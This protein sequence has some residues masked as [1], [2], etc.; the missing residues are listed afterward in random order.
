MY[1]IIKAASSRKNL[2]F[3]LE[4]KFY[5]NKFAQLLRSASKKGYYTK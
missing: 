4:T 1:C 3:G 2:T 5:L